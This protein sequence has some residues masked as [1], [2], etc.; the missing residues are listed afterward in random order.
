MPEPV[1]AGA[2]VA[3][4]VRWQARLVPLG[5]RD[6]IG[7]LLAAD[8]RWS[9]RAGAPLRWVPV[10][11]TAWQIDDPVGVCDRLETRG[12]ALWA[13]ITFTTPP[14][15]ATVQAMLE[16][17]L[18]PAFDLGAGAVGHLDDSDGVAFTYASG[19]ISCVYLSETPSFGADVW[20][21]PVPPPT[22]ATF[23]LTARCEWSAGPEGAATL[24]ALAALM[25]EHGL[26][27][28][29]RIFMDTGPAYALGLHLEPGDSLGVRLWAQALGLPRCPGDDVDSGWSAGANSPHGVW[30]GWHDVR[31]SSQ[32][33]G[34]AFDGD[35][36]E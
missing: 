32:A 25:D 13:I 4:P 11:A 16:R 19:E 12:G 24:R 14:D 27:E 18:R 5:V 1:D 28:P 3:G 21:E 2:A 7:S 6:S 30:L 36:G 23:E 29:A 20:F 26:P 31:V 8:G 17:R 33:R 22:E 34:E 15:P 9:L 35:G 10:A